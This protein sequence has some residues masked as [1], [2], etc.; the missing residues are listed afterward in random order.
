MAARSRSEKRLEAAY[1]EPQ[2]RSLVQR[3]HTIL[4]LG[5]Y[6]IQ[7]KWLLLLA[8]IM[9]VGSNL[10]ALVGPMLSGYAIDAIEP[11]MGKVE[12]SRVFHYAGWMA[13]F[14]VIS[15]VLSYALSVLMIT[16]SRK[17]VYRMRKDVFDKMLALPAG[18]YDLHQTGDIISR[19]SYDIDTVNESLSSDLI[20]IL[21]TVIT[22]G[23]ALYMMVVISPRLVLVFAFT[24]PLSACITKFITGKTRPLFRARSASLGNLNGFVEEMVTGQ[25]TLK[26]YCQEENVIRKFA[27]RNKDAVETYYRAEYY[28]SVVG[29]MVNFINNLSLSLISVF[30]ALLYLVGYMT[31]GQISSFVLYSRKFSGPINEAANIMSDLQ[32]AL[33]AAERVFVLMDEIPETADAPGAAELGGEGEEVR[34]EVE[35]SH[36]DFGYEKDRIILHDLSL[37]ADPGRLIAVVGPTGAGKTTLINLLMRFYD[38]NSGEIR[39]DGH[40]IREVT[41]KSLRKS[42]AMVLQ[43]TWLFHGSI[44]ENLAYGKE[45]ATMEEVVAAAKAARIHSFIKRLPE[46]YDTILTDDGT[47]IS[48]GQKQLLTI[49][50]AMLLEA[51]MLILDEAT[52]NVDTRTE[53]QIQEAMRKLMEGKTCFVIA[54]RLSTIRNADLILVIK[55]G[56]VVEKG[57]HE[58]LMRADGEYFQ[59]YTA[60]GE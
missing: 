22:V 35:L 58:E 46:G 12:F 9:T 43:D 37:K 53:V 57:T 32:S 51:R 5:R 16:I 17:V 26:A 47:N 60:Q 19:I 54:H 33:A 59:M 20:Q 41:R 50:R 24:V 18:Y 23:G 42:Y 40:E 1:N 8:F 34:G 7:Y 21:T 10:L 30:G 36:V 52:S 56:E 39:V 27:E 45:G 55:Q 14:Y 44:Y 6:M 31:V 3:K 38:P 2:G 4:R 28:G 49:A 29:P 13:A 48:K 25:K 15:S 11:G